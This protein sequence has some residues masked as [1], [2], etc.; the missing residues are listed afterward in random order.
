MD[1]TLA[2]FIAVNR[3]ELLRR[4]AV[5]V[6]S[7]SSSPEA[8]S[9]PESEPGVALFLDQLREELRPGASKTTEIATGAAKQGHALLLRGLTVGEVVHRYGDICQSVTDLSVEIGVDISAEDFRTLNRCL[10]DAIAGAVTEY[11][12]GQ[13][14]G[15]SGDAH[16]LR[17]LT[18]A[19]L[20]AFEALQMGVVGVSGRTGA[21]VHR[22]LLDIRAILDRSGTEVTTP[23]CR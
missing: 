23:G 3:R 22:T 10:D 14:V 13:D 5:K 17:K 12:H 6:A 15:R 8:E 1:A 19:A 18:D 7:R 11:A 16:E 9:I 4:C 21:H 2:D 20:I